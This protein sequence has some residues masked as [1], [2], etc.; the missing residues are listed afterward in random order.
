MDRNERLP[1][2]LLGQAHA[3]DFRPA[4]CRRAHGGQGRHLEGGAP[5]HHGPRQVYA[6][7]LLDHLGRGFILL[8]VGDVPLML[9]AIERA[10]T[11]LPH[12]GCHD[13]G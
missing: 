3:G 4:G 1:R 2:H 10:R 13:Q 5:V 7:D 11:A 6:F 12:Q 9:A 8:A